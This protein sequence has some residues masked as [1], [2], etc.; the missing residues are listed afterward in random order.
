[1]VTQEQTDAWIIHFM[2]RYSRFNEDS[3]GGILD[4]YRTELSPRLHDIFDHYRG[5]IPLENLSDKDKRKVRILNELH[6]SD[7]GKSNVPIRKIYKG[8]F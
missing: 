8:E 7:A 4:E 3:F 2:A 5:L 1:M 6:L